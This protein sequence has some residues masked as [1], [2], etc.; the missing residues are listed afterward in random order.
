MNYPQQLDALF[1]DYVK[2]ANDTLPLTGI[3]LYGS[4]ALGG[5]EEGKSDIDSVTIINDSNDADLL[6]KIETIHLT[7]VEQ[8]PEASK[9]DGMYIPRAMVGHLNNEM[10]PYPYVYDGKVDVGHWDCNAVTWWTLKTIGIALYG[11]ELQIPTTFD[12][13]KEA[14]IYN[15]DVY[16][17]H[18]AE[19]IGTLLDPT[20]A[21][22]SILTLCR[23][24]L[25]LTNQIFLPKM[26]AGKRFLEEEPDME[27]LD[28]VRE[29]LNLRANTTADSFYPDSL[30][31]A[32]RIVAFIKSLR[33]WHLKKAG[34]FYRK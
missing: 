24:H 23:I 28:L 9:M 33:D 11:P 29:G 15:L 10:P 22:D 12:D 31:R 3:Y 4:I 7:L 2:L 13:V 19:R 5:Y 21:A 34:D 6:H 14:M 16:W 17:K 27:W 18:R 26:A 20:D 8:H 25:T 1:K 30:T 32:E